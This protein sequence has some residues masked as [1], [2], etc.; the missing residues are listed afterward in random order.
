MLVEGEDSAMEQ[1]N[2]GMTDYEEEGNAAAAAA[3]GGRGWLT[4]CT[5]KEGEG[6]ALISGLW[7]S[8]PVELIDVQ[9]GIIDSTTGAELWYDPSAYADPNLSSLPLPRFLLIVEKEGI[10]RRLQEDTFCLAHVPSIIVTGCGFPDVATRHFVTKL[11]SLCPTLTP[12]GLCDYNPYGLA[13]LLTYS[14][15]KDQQR[16]ASAT[17]VARRGRG[18]SRFETAE[19]GVPLQWLGFRSCHVT[20]LRDRLHASAFQPLTERDYTQ[21]ARLAQTNRVLHSEQY[22][23]EVEAMQKGAFYHHHQD[24]ISLQLHKSFHFY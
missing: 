3:G 13:L 22:L 12:L 18:R 10:F 7:T 20:E 23:E 1:D 4:L 19:L 11:F 17:T 14:P 2:S 21:L 6:E 5:D 8:T 16:S 24:I 9:V 15:L